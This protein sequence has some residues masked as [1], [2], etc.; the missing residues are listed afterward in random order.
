MKKYLLGL[1][2]ATS[3]SAVALTKE[4]QARIYENLNAARQEIQVLKQMLPGFARKF[5]EP[6]LSSIDFK[7]SMSQSILSETSAQTS[8]YYVCAVKTP[9]DGSFIGK[10]PSQTEASYAALKSCNSST[11]NGI[12][13][14]EKNMVCEKVN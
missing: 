2:V 5:V 7:I 6:S 12:W 9:F 14:R 11:N 8:N 4:E 1:I 3:V 10:G 13:C